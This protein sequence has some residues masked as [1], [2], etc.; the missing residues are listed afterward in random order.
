VE[1]LAAG[2][3]RWQNHKGNLKKVVCPHR[4]EVHWQ[5]SKIMIWV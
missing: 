1:L 3:G 4:G 2:Y 5:V